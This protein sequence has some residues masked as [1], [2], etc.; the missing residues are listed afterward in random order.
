M[1]KISDEARRISYDCGISGLA[2]VVQR[3]IDL[4]Q[5]VATLAARVEAS[6]KASA[7]AHLRHVE[8]RSA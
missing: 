1:A 3:I 8:K 5:Q 7:P 4:E 2:P 6:E